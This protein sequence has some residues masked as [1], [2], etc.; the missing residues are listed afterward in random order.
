[1]YGAHNVAHC[2]TTRQPTE[3][4]FVLVVQKGKQST[5]TL[6]TQAKGLGTDRCTKT[7]VHDLSVVCADVFRNT[8]IIGTDVF[9]LGVVY[10][11]RVEGIYHTTNICSSVF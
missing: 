11:M 6:S 8:V 5:H 7:A 1:M 3:D 4:R 10:T 9:V 2:E